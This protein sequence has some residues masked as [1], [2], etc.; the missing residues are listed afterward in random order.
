MKKL[1]LEIEE[2]QVETFG[3]GSGEGRGTV[4]GRGYTDLCGTEPFDDSINYCGSAATACGQFSCAY[5]CG[6]TCSC[7]CGGTGWG[8][9]TCNGPNGGCTE[10]DIPVY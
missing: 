1:K 2:L 5:T 8:Q 3:T 10:P 9:Y 7:G 6:N 4:R